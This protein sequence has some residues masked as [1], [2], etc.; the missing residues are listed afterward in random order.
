MTVPPSK[1]ARSQMLAAACLAVAGCT[2]GSSASP[3]QDPN[4]FV[5]A[6]GELPIVVRE[7]AELQ[8][9]SRK[10]YE[11]GGVVSSVCHGAVGLLNIK[12]SDGALLVKG[13]RVTGFSNEEERLA[14]LDKHV[15]YLTEDELKK[16]GANYVK[17]EAPWAAF[18][19][20]DGRLVTGQ[21]PASGGKVAD[22][23]IA[24]LRN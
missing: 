18:A 9:L 4:L 3:S 16:R 21:N 12:L 15:P 20:A 10:I 2:G 24:A 11:K 13:K 14:E 17:A 19:I 8:A 1:L 23:V 22:L 6:K 7:N 5:V